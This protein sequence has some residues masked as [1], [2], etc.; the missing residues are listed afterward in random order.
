MKFQTAKVIAIGTMVLCC[1][2]LVGCGSRQDGAVADVPADANVPTAGSDKVAM[3][4]KERQ[5]QLFYEIDHKLV[6]QSCQQLMRLSRAGKLS[7]RTYYCDDPAVRWNELPEPIRALQPTDVQVTEVMVMIGF[8]DEGRTQSLRCISSEFGEPAPSEGGAKGMAFRKNPFGM[9]RLS[10]KESLEDLNE[11]YDHFEMELAP[12]LAYQVSKEDKQ[13]TTQDVKQS[14]ERMAALFAGM[15]KI[16]DELTVKKQRL[17]YRTDHNDLLK[18]CRG[19]IAQ[20]NEG[21]FTHDKI[22]IGNEC[23]AKDVKHIPEII[24]KL[25][26][27]YVW[28]EKNRVMVALIGGLDHAGVR[29]Y[30]NSSEATPEEDSFKLIDGLLYYDDGLREADADYRDYLK[31]L[32]KEA[33]P[34]LDWKRKQMNSP[35]PAADKASQTK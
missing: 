17:L 28:L 18:A 24:L 27:V 16:R 1:C 25:E 34:Y 15:E 6:Y 12:G 32:Q 14:G 13:R 19:I 8:L 31:S 30:V 10:G 3:G 26:P 21:V 33:I 2:G 20:Y 4:F 11:R 5:K 7:N 35:I 9:D 23:S 29:A 22:D